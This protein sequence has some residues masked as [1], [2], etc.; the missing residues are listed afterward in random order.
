MMVKEVMRRAS[1]LTREA[2][3]PD[4][5]DAIQ[6]TGCEA[7]PIVESSNGDV[8]VRQLVA[9]R[10][11]PS[12]RLV[13]ASATRGHAVGSTVLDL[14]AALGRRPGRFPTIDPYAAL[15]DAW[16]LMSDA[17]LTHLPV[18]EDREVVGMVSLVVTFSEFPH[19]SPA[20]GFWS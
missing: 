8:V 16:G 4:L 15:A 11:L 19:R 14:M 6:R 7:L 1:G 20:A 17:H 5:L 3:L 9:V 12:L 13:E 18:V 10:D 2:T